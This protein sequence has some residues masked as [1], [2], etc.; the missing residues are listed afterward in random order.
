MTSITQSGA[1]A[2]IDLL[3]DTP[4][5]FK[6]D[7]GDYTIEKSSVNRVRVSYKG[8]TLHKDKK[9]NIGA[10]SIVEAL[11]RET[12][13]TKDEGIGRWEK[14][15]RSQYLYEWKTPNFGY[16]LYIKAGSG[17]R[18]AFKVIFPSR[19]SSKSSE[20]L[21]IAMMIARE[22]ME[23]KDA[24]ELEYTKKKKEVAE[25]VFPETLTGVG[26]KTAKKLARKGI[27]TFEEVKKRGHYYVAGN[28]V[29]DMKEDAERHIEHGKPVTHYDEELKEF[30]VEVVLEEV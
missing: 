13:T 20:S 29:E 30:T 23:S 16:S 27:T 9:R 18:Y 24:R 7:L 12:S 3:D 28:Y 8:H 25:K 5:D 14:V 17:G 15:E 4:S 21:D 11:S 22:F 10:D 2:I 19:R 26:P 6:L 1:E